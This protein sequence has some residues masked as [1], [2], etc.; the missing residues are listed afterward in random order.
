MPLFNNNNPVLP[1][2]PTPPA[3]TNVPVV[4]TASL[5]SNLQYKKNIIGF[6]D[7][8]PWSGIYYAQYLGLDDPVIN[9]NDVN[10]PTLKQYL[11]IHDFELRVTSPLSVSVDAVTGTS[12]VGCEANV[13]PVITPISGDIFIAQIEN[14]LYGIFEV[15]TVI[16]ASLFKES[17]WTINLSQIGYKEANTIANYDVFAVAELVFDAN[18]LTIG[19]NPLSTKSEVEQKIEKYSLIQSLI[20][21]YYLNFFDTISNTFIVPNLTNESGRVYD[22]FLVKYWNTIIKKE[23]IVGFEFP[24]EYALRHSFCSKPFIT[25]FDALQ[26][27][28]EDYL[29]YS[30][31]MMKRTSVNKFN[32][33]FQRHSL[34]ISNLDYVV[35]PFISN[36]LPINTLTDASID[37]N[38]AITPYVVSEKFY[39]KTVDQSVIELLLNKTLSN[40]VVLFSE[41]TPLITGLDSLTARERFYRIPVI[42]SLLIISR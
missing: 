21:D 4:D 18:Q 23:W 8:S 14:G 29:K 17:A 20:N 37:T 9:S 10:D 40:Q 35:Y 22:P 13:Y 28:R 30:V 2:I 5:F 16:R 1:V 19:D 32:V 3:I 33:L 27:Q 12:T 6:L 34:K 42:I 31:K 26:L 24:T 7:G 15:T 39:N 11:K 25:F 38:L 36:S 41:V